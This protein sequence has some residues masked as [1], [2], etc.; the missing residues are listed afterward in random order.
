MEAL[1]PRARR[2]TP[3]C[4]DVRRSSAA[5][6]HRRAPARDRLLAVLG[7]LDRA[8]RPPRAP[9]P[10]TGRRVTEARPRTVE[11]RTA[12]LV[13]AVTQPRPS[14]RRTTPCA[15]RTGASCSAS[16]RST[17]PRADPIADPAGRRPRPSPTSPRRRSRPRWPSP[18]TEVGE[19]ADALPAR[20]HRHGQDAAAR[21]E[22]RQ[23]RRRH[24]RRRAGRRRR[25]RTTALARRHGAG[26]PPDAGL[27]DLDRRGRA[28]AGRR[29]AAPRGQERP[30][31][32]HRRRATGPTTSA[33]PR[34][35]SSRRCSRRGRSAG[36][37]ELGQALHGRRS[38]PMVWE[39]AGPRRTSSRTCR[40]CAAGSS[41]TCPPA[42]ADRQ[43]KLGPGGL[44]DVEFSVQLLQLVHG[45]ADES[46][47]S[48][49]TLE[50]LGR[51][52]RA[53]ATSGAT[54]PRPSTRPT[55]SCAPS[56]TAS[57]CYR[58]RRTHLMPTAEADLRR[59]G[60][61]LG[62]R[63]A[64]RRGRGGRSGRP[65]AREVRRL[66]ERLFYRPLLAAVARLQH[67]RGAAD[68]RGRAGAAGRA[69]LPRPRRR[70]A[71]PRGAH[72]RASAGAPPSSG[73]LLP[74]M[75]GWFA[76]EAD[77]DAGLLAFRQVSDELGSTHWYLRLLRDEG[78]RRRAA[79]AHPGPQPVS[80]PT[81]SCA[82]RRASRSSATPAA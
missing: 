67:L 26:D 46:L 44:R 62:H 59:L 50:A 15:S 7:A 69:R 58:L 43:L 51:A 17:S 78:S 30:A 13:E 25:T 70:A 33:G 68:A 2:R 79:G 4:A 71:P 34:P 57:S 12:H 21:A 66:H 1:A 60:R 45:R 53:A 5:L 20:G 27:L 77:P 42:E 28:V 8:R 64:A 56:S 24:L 31:G 72:H 38:A 19:Q 29:G 75:L 18:A 6:R 37:Q 74:V 41:S 11:E 65:Q 35:G 55:G 3:G 36:D 52:G 22:L 54:T 80:P 73:T 40:R 76:D 82:R 39:A 49:T 16:P 14:T 48:G 9:T 10:S 61:A 47:R 63:A 32:A 81:C 23:R